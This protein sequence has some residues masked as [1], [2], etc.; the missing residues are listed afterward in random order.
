M[1]LTKF[2]DT[3]Q[4]NQAHGDPGTPPI[5]NRFLTIFQADPHGVP[6]GA[7]PPLRTFGTSPTSSSPAGCSGAERPGDARAEPDPVHGLGCRHQR[8]TRVR[9]IQYAIY[10][11]RG[12]WHGQEAAQP[13]ERRLQ[14]RDHLL[15]LQP[16]GA[17]DPPQQLR[18]WPGAD[19]AVGDQEQQ[20]A[21]S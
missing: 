6:V 19:E 12:V 4:W 20:A 18:P 9:V 8:R 21:R 5:Y 3:G 14:R 13:V 7:L 16:A 11:T 10:D 17:R 15:R 2:A 1:N